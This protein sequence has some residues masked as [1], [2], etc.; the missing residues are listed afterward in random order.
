MKHLEH[1]GAREVVLGHDHLDGFAE[2]HQRLV[3][4]Q[5]VFEL[6]FYR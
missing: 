6:G 2:P 4:L 1:F 3:R 5:G